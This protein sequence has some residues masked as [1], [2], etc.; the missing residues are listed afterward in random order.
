VTA[1]NVHHIIKQVAGVPHLP[2]PWF[3]DITQQGEALADVGTHLVDRAH[4][5]PFS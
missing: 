1:A 3:F 5:T 4:S 2:P